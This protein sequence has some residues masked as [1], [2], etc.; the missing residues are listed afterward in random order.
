[1]EEIDIRKPRGFRPIDLC[2]VL[3]ILAVVVGLV[4]PAILKVREAAARTQCQSNLKQIALGIHDYASAY[5]NQLPALSDAPRQDIGG[6]PAWHP[7]S[8]FFAI[9]PFLESNPIYKYGMMEPMGRT[10]NGIDPAPGGGPLFCTCFW[11]TYCCPSDSSNSTTQPVARGWVGC[12][13][14]AN[15]QVFGSKAEVVGDPKVGGTWNVLG[16]DFDINS[17]PDGTATTIFV[18]ERFAVAGGVGTGTPCSWIDPPAGGAGLGNMEFD[19]MG[20]PLQ[21]F[22]SSHGVI[23]ASL[24]GPGTFYA[25]GTRDDPVGARGGVWKY[26]LPE[27]GLSPVAAATDGRPQS[28]HD[29]VVQVAM[30]DGSIRGISARVSQVTW[31]RAICPDDGQPL[32]RDW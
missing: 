14:A 3:G 31:V 18:A 27:I 13:Y 1:M 25:L 32:G 5:L 26:P 2:V 21:S 17:I 8:L 16:P 20:C 4:L 28:E 15:A 9:G 22:V 29:A 19:A 30:G 7:Q 24:C 6:V 10:W 11:K 23:R 12:S